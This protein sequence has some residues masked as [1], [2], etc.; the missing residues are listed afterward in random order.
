M[1]ASHC[2]SDRRGHSLWRA[3]CTDHLQMAAIFLWHH[4]SVCCVSPLPDWSAAEKTSKGCKL[5]LKPRSLFAFFA[6]PAP[7]VSK[8]VGFRLIAWNSEKNLSWRP[9]W[10]GAV[11]CGPLHCSLCGVFSRLSGFHPQSKD[12]QKSLDQSIKSENLEGH[13]SRC[14]NIFDKLHHVCTTCNIS[15][16]FELPTLDV[17]SKENGRHVDAVQVIIN[18]NRC[19]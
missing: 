11:L 6:F 9:G 2:S 4:V 19:C 14:S 10:G 3:A 5:V 12:M 1:L 15:P 13:I 8:S 17:T 7:L 16:A 18:V